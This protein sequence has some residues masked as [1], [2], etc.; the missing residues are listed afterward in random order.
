MSRIKRFNP[1]TGLWEYADAAFSGGVAKFDPTVYDLPIL[2][3]TGDI[4][5][6]KVSKDNEVTL[7]YVYGERSGTCTMKGQGATSYAI[8]QSLG[9]RGKFNYT[10]KFDNPFEAF[11]GYGEQ[12]KDCLKASLIDPTHSRNVCSCKTWGSM[13]KSRPNAPAELT[14]LPNGGA[15]D[16]FPVIIMLNGEFH[17]LYTFN[18]PKDGW[19]FGLV[20]DTTKTQAIVA[21]KDH[22]A[23]TQFKA[24]S[25][26]G[27][28]AEWASD[29]D[30]A[31]W[32]E[33]SMTRMLTAVMNSDGSDLDAVVSQY[34]DLDSVIDYLIHAVVDKAP[35]CIDKNFLLVTFDGTKW[36]I[37][38]YDRDTIWS[39]EWDASGLTRPVSNV[40]FL[41]CAATSH[42]FELIVRF[43]TNRLKERYFEL[44][45]D[46]LSESRLMQ[47]VEN[48]AW[49][50]PAPVAMEDV[51]RWPSIKGSFVNTVDQIGRFFRQRLPVV[52]GWANALPAQETP[53]GSGSAVTGNLVPLSTDTDGS[54]Y[55]G[56]GYKDGVRLSSSG[57]VSSTAQTGS[58]TTGFIPFTLTDV[59]RI[60]GAEWLSMTDADT[61]HYY[62]NF[63]DSGK[64]FIT[65]GSVPASGYAEN[66]ADALSVTYDEATGVTTFGINE[67][68][69]FAT[70]IAAAAYFRINAHGSGADLIVTVNEEIA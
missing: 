29:E 53:G 70:T 32:V 42:L 14:S 51:K 55:N 31:G 27:Y 7:D 18:I 48:F 35:D 45:K 50:I 16:G 20:E 41:E 66:Y 68:S 36:Y 2:Y 69:T 61:G 64:T 3:L 6:I 56:V 63:Y 52:D 23:A 57:G 46:T 24:A 34:I 9:D 11:P 21:A 30:N 65:N 8:A 15:I 12:E 5:P 40:S 67:D 13:V 44:R 47:V 39:L 17:G 58:V 49:A 1:K 59:I 54:I 22:T 60:R 26:T 10:I 4:S 38:D 43:K 25:M 62:L 28:E 19:M 37:S 33:T